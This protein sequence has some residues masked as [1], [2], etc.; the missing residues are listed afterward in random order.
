MTWTQPTLPGMGRMKRTPLPKENPR[1][2]EGPYKAGS[3]ANVLHHHPDY[4]HHADA[5]RTLAYATQDDPQYEAGM[6]DEHDLVWERRNV[7]L[8]A[9]KNFSTTPGR[10]QATSGFDPRDTGLGDSRVRHAWTGFLESR[11]EMTRESQ[12]HPVPPILLIKRGS[13]YEVADGHHRSEA[14]KIYGATHIN[15]IVGRSPHKD[16]VPQVDY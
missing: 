16:A 4:E 3:W 8:R 12:E 1:A 14:A 9:V 2:I 7:P 5:V 15:A 11:G 10:R 13:N 6:Q